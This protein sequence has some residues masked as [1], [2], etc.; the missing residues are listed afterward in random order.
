[1]GTYLPGTGTLGWVVWSG[2]GSL[3][4]RVLLPDFYLPHV[5]VGAP[6]FC[7]CSSLSHS[8]ML[9]CTSPA[10]HTSLR[11]S[12]SPPL[13]P[14]WMNVASLNP[15][16]SDFHTAQ[17]SDYSGWYLFCS[18]VVIF[19][20]VWEGE[21]CYLHLY[22]DQSLKIN[23]VSLR[24]LLLLPYPLGYLEANCRP[25]MSSVNISAWDISFLTSKL[26]N[27]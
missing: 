17:F 25:L 22:L 7:P 10:L 15:C 5:D 19:V 12:A 14:V 23:L 6:I 3:A 4:L 13:L 1:M 9:L 20:V 11:I 16:L 27:S 18:L 26:I 21:A 8:A 24:Q 2:A